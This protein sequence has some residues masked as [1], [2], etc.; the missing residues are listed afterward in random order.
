M[1]AEDMIEDFILDWLLPLLAFLVVITAVFSLLPS[2]DHPAPIAGCFR[3]SD[4]LWLSCKDVWS[5]NP[6]DW[7]EAGQE[8]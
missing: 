8:I 2:P 3:L 6:L 4:G 5:S 1:T 7:W